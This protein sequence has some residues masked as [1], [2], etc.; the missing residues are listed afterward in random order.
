M[1]V[2][3]LTAPS[4]IQR[5]YIKFYPDAFYHYD[6]YNWWTKRPCDPTKYDDARSMPDYCPLSS[7]LLTSWKNKH[8]VQCKL[9]NTDETRKYIRNQSARRSRRILPKEMR[10]W[11]NRNEFRSLSNRRRREKTVEQRQCRVMFSS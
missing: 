1:L 3:N 6:H 9:K 5:F 4:A 2:N 11:R 8:Q 10:K 7:S